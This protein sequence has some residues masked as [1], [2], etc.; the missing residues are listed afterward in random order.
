VCYYFREQGDGDGLVGP[1]DEL[2]ITNVGWRLRGEVFHLLTG[3]EGVGVIKLPSPLPYVGGTCKLS[4]PTIIP[5]DVGTEVFDEVTYKV[6]GVM[7]PADPVPWKGTLLVLYSFSTGGEFDALNTNNR[8]TGRIQGWVV[9]ADRDGDVSVGDV[10]HFTGLDHRVAGR[11]IVVKRAG[12]AVGTAKLPLLLHGGDEA[13]V[14]LAGMLEAYEGDYGTM[15]KVEYSVGWVRPEGVQVPWSLVN[16][17]VLDAEDQRTLVGRF[18]LVRDE[19]QESP[20]NAILIEA[21]PVDGLASAGDVV[22]FRGFDHTLFAALVR[23]DMLGMGLDAFPLP[24]SLERFDSSTFKLSLERPR[25]SMIEVDGQV[26]WSV[27]MYVRNATDGSRVQWG[28]MTLD[29]IAWNG[30]SIVEGLPLDPFPEVDGTQEWEGFNTLELSA[31]HI[32]PLGL[33][34]EGYVGVTG[35]AET[36]GGAWLVLRTGGVRAYVAILPGTLP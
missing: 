18:P 14:F 34:G 1:G 31:W 24:W 13:L 3:G 21:S 12:M 26:R 33:E 4:E 28:G 29:V 17:T 5:Y 8:H 11:R 15:F 7:V 27:I 36:H 22:I 25:F 16:V 10:V 9:D 23:L 2:V 35:L 6:V 20:I 19:K 32:A 30:T